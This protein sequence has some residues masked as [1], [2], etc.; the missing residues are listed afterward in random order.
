MLGLGGRRGVLVAVDQ[1][2]LELLALEHVEP[3]EDA[4]QTVPVRVVGV[5]G[6]AAEGP[7]LPLRHQLALWALERAQQQVVLA[8]PVRD[9]PPEPPAAPH[10]DFRRKED[11]E[12]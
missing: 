11:D 10:Q 8:G 4:R 3:V 7:E 9:P 1:P 12:A 5:V 2:E 6:A